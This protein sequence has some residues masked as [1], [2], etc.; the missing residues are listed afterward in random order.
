VVDARI[1][2]LERRQRCAVHAI[3]VGP[4]V[5][6]EIDDAKPSQDGFDLVLSPSRIVAQHEIDAAPW[7]NVF[8]ANWTRL[9][10][11]SPAQL[12]AEAKPRTGQPHKIPPRQ[13]ASLMAAHSGPGAKFAETRRRAHEPRQRRVLHHRRGPFSAAPFLRGSA[14]CLSGRDNQPQVPDPDVAELRPAPRS[15]RRP[16]PT[17]RARSHPAGPVPLTREGTAAR[18]RSPADPWQS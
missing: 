6:I 10:S 12:S 14:N 3:Q 1:V 8:H 13:I 9:A 5:V 15:A 2:L 18:M 16:Y 7:R 4:A 17:L 11:L